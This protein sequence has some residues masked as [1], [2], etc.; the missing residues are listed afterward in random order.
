M[1]KVKNDDGIWF[2]LKFMPNNLW[3][4]GDGNGINPN[5]NLAEQK[6]NCFRNM[7]FNF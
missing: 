7:F 5:V 2:G 6:K 4:W 1:F 3:S